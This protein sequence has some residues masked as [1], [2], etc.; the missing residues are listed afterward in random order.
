M[1]SSQPTKVAFTFRSSRDVLTL[2]APVFPPIVS[3]NLYTPG[4]FTAIVW[5]YSVEVVAALL[6]LKLSSV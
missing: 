2:P 1:I 3:E 4:I 5:L 6:I